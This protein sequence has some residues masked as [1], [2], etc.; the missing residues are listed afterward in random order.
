MVLLLTIKCSQMKRN[1]EPLLWNLAQCMCKF[2]SPCEDHKKRPSG[3]LPQLSSGSHRAT[4]E[5]V[6]NCVSVQLEEV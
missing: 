5:N 4:T 3:Q 2:L 1:A 6:H